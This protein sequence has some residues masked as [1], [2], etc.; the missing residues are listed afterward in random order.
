M[1][2]KSFFTLIFIV[3]VSL[4][5]SILI[6]EK[7]AVEYVCSNPKMRH[8]RAYDTCSKWT[9]PHWIPHHYL[10]YQGNPKISQHNSLGLRGP[11]IIIPKPKKTYRIIITGGSTAYETGVLHW[12][13]DTARQL[14]AE[15]RHYYNSQDIEV[16]NGGIS[17]YNSWETL[18]NLEMKLIDLGPDLVIIYDNLNDIKARLVNPNFYNGDN[19]GFR[20]IF[21]NKLPFPL[22]W[23]FVRV[24]AK[25][26]VDIRYYFESE[27]A[28]PDT[29]PLGHIPSISGTASEI[30]AKNKP[31]YFLRNLRSMFALAREFKFDVVI[32][33]YAYTD[34]IPGDWVLLKHYRDG[35]KEHNDLIRE[36]SSHY[37]VYFYD[38]QAEFPKD[39]SLFF[40]G[41]HVNEKGAKLKAQL[42]AKYIINKKILVNKL[43]LLKKTNQK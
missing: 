15:L 21:D 17:G 13:D 7:L 42:F 5:G 27:H 38:H 4:I 2:Y 30:L 8:Y 31:I 35:V 9:P 19:S 43:D 18:I 28:S 12:K 25:K 26:P 32:A 23:T 11:E 36:I 20:K 40:D 41:R 24:A 34:Q 3:I 14:Q 29:A 22:N 39:A 37:P 6:I 10:T 33:T 16:I 1:K